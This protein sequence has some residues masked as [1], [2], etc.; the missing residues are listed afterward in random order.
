MKVIRLI[1]NHRK[2]KMRIFVSVIMNWLKTQNY[3]ILIKV[4][5]IKNVKNKNGITNL[6]IIQGLPRIIIVKIN[7]IKIQ[8]LNKLKNRKNG[9]M[10]SPR[11]QGLLKIIKIKVI[12]NKT[13]K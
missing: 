11:T 7:I 8:S 12:I 4:S 1:I 5:N 13:N 9:T 10:K 3:L 6:Q 2:T